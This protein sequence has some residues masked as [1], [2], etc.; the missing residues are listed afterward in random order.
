MIYLRPSPY[1][2]RRAPTYERALLTRHIGH[3]VGVLAGAN[4]DAEPITALAHCPDCDLWLRPSEGCLHMRAVGG[5]A[6]HLAGD[7]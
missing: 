6:P 4:D 5:A 1:F 2:T 7:S 3:F